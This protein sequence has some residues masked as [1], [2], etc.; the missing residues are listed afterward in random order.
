MQIGKV[1]KSEIEEENK[2]EDI[3][4]DINPFLF[5]VPLKL[6]K[7][8]TENYITTVFQKEQKYTKGQTYSEEQNGNMQISEKKYLE[9]FYVPAQEYTTVYHTAYDD[10]LFFKKLKGKSIE[11]FHYIILNLEKDKDYI[12][13]NNVKV[14]KK[15]GMSKKSFYNSVKELKSYGIIIEK[16]KSEYWVNYNYLFNGDRTKY[17]TNNSPKKPE[18]LAVCTNGVWET[19]VKKSD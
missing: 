13:L 4:R 9:Y 19:V 18:I 6:N 1:V 11:L 16:I 3:K 10:A 17:Y 8:V 15:T 2:I 7:I 14:C 12:D 5:G